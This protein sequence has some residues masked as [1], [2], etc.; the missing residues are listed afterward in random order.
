MW[1]CS[2]SQTFDCW[3]EPWW[4]SGLEP[5]SHCNLVML[6]VEGSNPRPSLFQYFFRDPSKLGGGQIKTWNLN[7]WNDS[8]HEVNMWLVK[9][10]LRQLTDGPS[11]EKLCIYF[12]GN[13]PRN[14]FGGQDFPAFGTS[15]ALDQFQQTSSGCLQYSYHVKMTCFIW[16]I[17][18][19]VWK[20]EYK[21]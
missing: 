12:A 17:Y 4:S 10:G 14:A 3:T 11:T 16:Y 5:W 1:D 13:V 19:C 21:K 6:K 15:L 8:N 9:G 20:R 7:F 18:H 2:G